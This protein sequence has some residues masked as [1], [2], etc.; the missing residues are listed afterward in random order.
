MKFK[1]KIGLLFF[2]F[3]VSVTVTGCKSET[4]K[5]PEKL[6]EK[7]VTN[8]FNY[9]IY[10]DIR[11]L[12]PIDTSF[13]LPKNAK[14]VGRI[15]KRDLNSDGVNEI[16]AF[17]KK[18]NEEQGINSIYMYIFE[19]DGDSIVDDSEKMITISGDSI[20]YADFVDINN[21]GK[22][23]IILQV[24]NRGFENIYVYEYTNHSVK[25]KAEFST[26]K[27]AIKLNI[28]DYNGDGKKE[29][30]ALLQDLTSYDVII[31]KMNII[32]GEI[33]FDKFETIKNV[34]SL[35]KVDIVN[36]YVAKNKIGS[37]FIYQNFNGSVITQIIIYKNGKFIKVLNDDNGKLKNPFFMRPYDINGS[38][39]LEIPKVEFKFSNNTPKESNVVSWY[40]WN[41][42]EDKNSALN[43]VN[44]RFY[45]YDYNFTISIP[46]NLVNR[47]F[48]R[49]KYEVDKSIFEFFSKT[50]DDDMSSLFKIVVSK[51]SGEEVDNKNKAIKENI[52]YENDEYSYVYTPSNNQNLEKY[53]INFNKI[54]SLF[55]IINK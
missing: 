25:K 10:N 55:E 27:Y 41:G 48:I 42:A 35:D 36:G 16:I 1:Q 50:S 28:F 5:S 2:C 38:K 9:K 47:F 11:K 29:C 30:L 3:I 34:D 21:D 51:K 33:E 12:T 19:S 8:E 49:Q 17:K 37:M 7:P 53:K 6:L 13:I 20:K 40:E 15:N 4:M 18:T 24:S 14:E 54:K 45:C 22:E 46:K 26:S 31:S 39:I 44:Q 23:E 43:I 52:I 32:D